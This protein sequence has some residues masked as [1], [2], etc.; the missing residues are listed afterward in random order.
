M[1]PRGKTE[2]SLE[3]R[4]AII[5]LYN[6][7]RSPTKVSQKLGVAKSTVLYTVRRQENHNTAK[8]LP[9]SGRPP[10]LNDYTRREILRDIQKDRLTN[11]QGIADHIEGVTGRQ[12]RDIAEK[13]G[14]HRRI[15][16]DKP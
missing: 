11:Y 15:A 6:E 3:K 12:V 16:R 7:T 13:A 2:L 8:S 10:A 1:T 4:G 9:R 14:Y 5:A